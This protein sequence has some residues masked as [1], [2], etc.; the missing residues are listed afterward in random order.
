M[1]ESEHAMTD[2]RTQKQR[3]LAG[4]LYLA[5]DP[6]L[7]AEHLSAQHL[8][9][10]FN[11]SA[12]DETAVRD[13]LLSRLFGHW[14]DGAVL[15]PAFRCDYGIHISIGAR[16]FV[17]YDC[18]FLDCNRIEIGEEVQ[19]GPGVHIYTAT[20]PLEATTRRSG[21]ESALPVR[22][23]DGAWIGGGSILCPGVTVGENTVI[24]AGSV[25]TRDLPGGVLAVGNPCR[26]VRSI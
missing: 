25:V 18:V 26:V 21:L 12:P 22:V 23:G 4:D 7:V 14:G 24:G 17:N 10:S 9:S 8:L 3:M 2:D 13:R 5:N 1:D 11:A 15:K 6:E 19:I 16:S 20:H